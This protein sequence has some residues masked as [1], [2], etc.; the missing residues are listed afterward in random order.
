MT[1][2][3]ARFAELGFPVVIVLAIVALFLVF[4]RQISRGAVLLKGH[5][6]PNISF[7]LTDGRASSIAQLKGNVLLLHFWAGW[8][9]PC[10]I[11]MPSLKKLE[12]EFN[13]RPFQILAFNVEDAPPSR[14]PWGSGLPRP[15][16]FIFDFSKIELDP[17]DLTAIPVS[18]IVDKQGKVADTLVGPQ[19][20]E[21]ARL[22]RQ[23]EALVN[24]TTH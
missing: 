24:S 4:K 13:G 16:R 15:K 19:E 3:E 22:R 6:A 1:N 14:E 17:Y 11:E 7:R 9:E 5:S 23:I 18:V 20:W 2:R 10:K 21:S 12:T 8:C